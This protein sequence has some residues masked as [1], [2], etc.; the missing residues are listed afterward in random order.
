MG[1]LFGGH[2]Q[3][4]PFDDMWI[5]DMVDSNKAG[6]WTRID[7]F[8]IGVKP[9][10]TSYHTLLYDNRTDL[11]ILFG[12]LNWRPTNLNS[13]DTD[14]NLDRRCEKEARELEGKFNGS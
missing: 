6:I 1:I 3:D 14:F 4:N 12:G 7:E 10:A 8:F 9:V 13:T 5:L 11:L 2:R